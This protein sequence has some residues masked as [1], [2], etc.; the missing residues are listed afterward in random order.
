M[1]GGRSPNRFRRPRRAHAS[2]LFLFAFAA[3]C[4]QAP[5]ASSSAP[6]QRCVTCHLSEYQSVSHPPHPG[7][8]PTTCGTCHLDSAWHPYRLDH[9]WPLEGAHAKTQCFDCHRGEPR[10]FEG[11]SKECLSCHVDDRADANQKLSRHEQFGTTCQT[12]HSTVAWKPTLPREVAA[13]VSD[14]V[15]EAPVAAP[16]PAKVVAP[17]APGRRNSTGTPRNTP[18]APARTPRPKPDTVTGAS[19]AWH[20]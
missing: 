17:A 18:A 7:V 9:S 5:Q 4:Q 16:K 14:E 2:W 20:K 19:P 3:S 11:T 12:C 8:R 6:S 15:T 1:Q 10:Q 13:T